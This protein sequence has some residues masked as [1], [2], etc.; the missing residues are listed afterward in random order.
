HSKRTGS[1]VVHRR[2]VLFR[3]VERSELVPVDERGG[4]GRRSRE[5]GPKILQKNLADYDVDHGNSRNRG[6]PRDQAAG[7]C[8]QQRACF[9]A[10]PAPKSGQAQGQSLPD[11]GRATHNELIGAWRELLRS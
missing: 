10:S 8:G 2:T 1:T 9:L 5:I 7:D 4:A 3:A 11:G 6:S